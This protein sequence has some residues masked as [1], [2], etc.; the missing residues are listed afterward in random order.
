MARVPD[1][2]KA[3]SSETGITTTDLRL[4]LLIDDWSDT[5]KK[6]ITKGSEAF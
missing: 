3:L 6:I 2:V 1:V 5:F 4:M